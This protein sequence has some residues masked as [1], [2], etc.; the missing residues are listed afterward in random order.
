MPDLKEPPEQSR[1]FTPNLKLYFW[2]KGIYF[3]I[4]YYKF[5]LCI[6]TA[7]LK[8]IRVRW[9]MMLRWIMQERL[10]IR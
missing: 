7:E 1:H 9:R 4:S 2:Y 8:S 5:L 3:D 6:F 10:M